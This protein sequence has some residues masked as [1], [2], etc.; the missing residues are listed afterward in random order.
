MIVLIVVGLAAG[1]CR[2]RDLEQA[3]RG[4]GYAGRGEHQEE[5]RGHDDADNVV[6][7]EREMLRDL[8]ITTAAAESRPAGDAVTVLGELRVNEDAYAEVGS[9][10]PARVARVLAAPGEVVTPGQALVEL[11]SAEV[12]RARANLSTARARLDLA[13]QTVERRHALAA[14][15]IVPQRDL[16]AAEAELA[17][18]E[19]EYRGAEQTISGMGALRGSGA[20]F[21]LTSPIAG[22]IIERRALRGRMTDAE[23]PLFVVGDLR[24]L[25]LIV[26]AFER[27]ALRVQTGTAARVTFPALPGQSFSG[28]VTW[29]GSQVDP[30]SRTIDVRIEVDNPAGQLRPGMSGSALVPLGSSGETVVAVPGAALQRVEEGWCVFLPRDEATFEIRP[31]GRGRDLGG[32]VEVLSGLR[33][34]ETVVVDGAFLLKAERDKRRGAGEEHEH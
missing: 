10:I 1:G 13:R 34:G 12:G 27:D 19:A 32:E 16:Q 21:T 22:T 7:I 24:R 23:H 2:N 26:H 18:A 25:W 17:Q 31:V 15:Q 11:E 8:R 14:D 9:P 6:R 29:I 33:P 5:A 30:S 20:R 3:E 4:G 28:T